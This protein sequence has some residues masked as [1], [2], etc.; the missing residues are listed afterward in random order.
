M[1]RPPKKLV[2]FS[3]F[4][5]HRQPYSDVLSVLKPGDIGLV[6]SSHLFGKLIR[7]GQGLADGEISPYNHA[8][9]VSIPQH[10]E[11]RQ[12]SPVGATGRQYRRPRLRHSAFFTDGTIFESVKNIQFGDLSKYIGK[13]IAIA[14]HVDM[15]IEHFVSGYPQ[16][17]NNIGQIYPAHRIVLHALDLLRAFVWRKL[18]KRQPMWRYAKF[19][20]LDRPVCSELVAQFLISAQLNGGWKDGDTCWRGTNPDHIWDA[21]GDPDSNMWRLI[22]V[23]VMTKGK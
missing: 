1:T 2:S 23:G 14:R 6:R 8:F 10:I 11:L 15:D 22:F 13:P 19:G 21:W 12:S 20:F 16:V 4:T 17:L 3:D 18:I 9:G 5:E 7:F